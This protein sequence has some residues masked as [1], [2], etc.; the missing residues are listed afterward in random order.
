MRPRA[1]AAMSPK[2][3]KIEIAPKL[4]RRQAAA[5]TEGVSKKGI[6][7]EGPLK[8]RKVV[9]ASTPEIPRMGP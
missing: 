3:E 2:I 9:G 5:A 6:E 8:D 1:E 4:A 7:I